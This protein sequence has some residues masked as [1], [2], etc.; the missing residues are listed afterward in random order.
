MQRGN[1]LPEVS[2]VSLVLLP[3][4]A[5]IQAGEAGIRYS[6]TLQIP[7]L[8]KAAACGPPMFTASERFSL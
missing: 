7:L 6:Y 3:K 2:Q 1:S 8:Y 5:F 4:R